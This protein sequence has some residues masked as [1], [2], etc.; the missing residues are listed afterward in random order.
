V[1]QSGNAGK[2]TMVGFD[3][4]PQTAE[5]VKSGVVDF[6]ISQNPSEQGYQAVKVLADFLKKGTKIDGVD[7]GAQIID[8]K[9]LADATVEG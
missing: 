4:L 1:Q 6:T 9:N 3:L 8:A 5:F 2:I 7:T